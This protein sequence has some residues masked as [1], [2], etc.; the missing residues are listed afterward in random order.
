[1]LVHETKK[2]IVVLNPKTG[3]TTLYDIF[4]KYRIGDRH[5]HYKNIPNSKDYKIF[6]FHRDPVDRFISAHSYLIEIYK[7]LEPTESTEW[8]KKYINDITITEL[9]ETLVS[10]PGGS[11][12]DLFQ[13]Q[14]N[15]LNSNVELLNYHDFE[16]ECKKLMHIFDID[17]NHVIPVRNNSG[18]KIVPTD[19]EKKLI[20][21]LY[22]KD[23][24]FF[25]NSGIHYNV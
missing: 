7:V 15:W 24:D 12:L 25:T 18:N 2:I 13:A 23:Y 4:E 5:C 1:M 16:N 10:D 3:T 8:Y 17:S 14:T 21:S 20:Q 22:K 9:I 19:I 6:G 11:I